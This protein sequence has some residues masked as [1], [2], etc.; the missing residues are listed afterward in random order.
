MQVEIRELR[1]EDIEALAEVEAEAFSMPWS[2]KDFQGLL[3]RSYCFYLVAL[4]DG[5]PVGC[6]GLHANCQLSRYLQ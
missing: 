4:A 2:K 6:C 5:C 1:E 3:E